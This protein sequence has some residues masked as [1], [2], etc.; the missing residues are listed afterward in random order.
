[1]QGCSL[2]T[3]LFAICL[4]PLIHTLEEVLTDIKIGRRR[5]RITAVAYAGDVTVF[6]TLPADVR[7]LQE[8]LRAYEE[9]TGAK[10]SIQKS[11]AIAIG[12]WDASN[13]ILDIPYYTGIKTLGFH[14]T[15][16]VNV[17]N[18]VNWYNVTSQ[19]RAATQ[20][21]YYRDLS[22]DRRI[23][24]VHE[25]LLARIWYAAQIFPITT[26]SMRQLKKHLNFL[27]YMVR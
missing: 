9:A 6:L 1:M 21:A 26:D 20:D 16:R 22:L 19:V 17:A 5:T 11:R 7:N 23:R 3:Q 15:D 13:K 18:K 4:N 10:I 2:G 25:Y 8:V 27:V 24:F 12:S 14:F